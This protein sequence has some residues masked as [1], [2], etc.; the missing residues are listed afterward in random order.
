MSKENNNKLKMEIECTT[1]DMQIQTSNNKVDCTHLGEESSTTTS[2]VIQPVS[3]QIGCSVLENDISARFPIANVGLQV[4]QPQ[5]VT[6]SEKTKIN[7]I[8]KP[9]K[10]PLVSKPVKDLI[11]ITKV[12]SCMDKE[13]GLIQSRPTTSNRL[14][15]IQPRLSNMSDGGNPETNNRTQSSI[16]RAIRKYSSSGELYS[17]PNK[18]MKTT[19][20]STKNF[21]NFCQE[22]L[23]RNEVECTSRVRIDHRDCTDSTD[24]FF[25]ENEN[26]TLENISIEPKED[27]EKYCMTAGR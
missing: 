21:P 20:G 17:Q 8:H 25:S 6:L 4:V 15:H 3:D 2:E 23:N 24:A 19:S 7:I 14:V 11:K 1:E 12:P 26:N 13:S 10:S 5:H 18:F 16:T 27:E 9:L 22:N